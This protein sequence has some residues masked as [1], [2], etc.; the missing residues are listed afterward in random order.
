MEKAMYYELI[1]KRAYNCGRYGTE[2][3][4]ADIY[5]H[6]GRLSIYKDENAIELKK[7]YIEYGTVKTYLILALNKILKDNE[8][9]LNEEQKTELEKV[10]SI[11]DNDYRIEVLDN[12]IDKIV[13]TL[14]NLAF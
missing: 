5:R 8:D 6:L 10:K 2:G 1:I 12:A 14:N 9:I 4:N 3:A 7:F 11:I 13:E